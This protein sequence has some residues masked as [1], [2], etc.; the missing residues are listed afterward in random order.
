MSGISWD[1][2]SLAHPPKQQHYNHYVN[3]EVG[4]ACNW[5]FKS[6]GIPASAIGSCLFVIVVRSSKTK[7]SPRTNRTA[8][9]QE[10][11]SL[12][13]FLRAGFSLAIR[14]RLASVDVLPSS[15]FLNRTNQIRLAAQK[16]M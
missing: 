9:Q 10:S 16:I 12:P 3:G 11:I 2:T 15:S 4:K 8:D 6:L 13:S 14:L 1:D 7:S 5:F